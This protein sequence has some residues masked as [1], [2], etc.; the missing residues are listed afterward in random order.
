MLLYSLSLQYMDT[1]KITFRLEHSLNIVFH[2]KY[3]CKNVFFSLFCWTSC[4]LETFRRQYFSRLLFGLHF[5]FTLCIVPLFLL[6]SFFSAL[7]HLTL[8][9]VVVVYFFTQM[10]A[11]KTG[12]LK[13][14]HFFNSVPR[15]LQD[16]SDNTVQSR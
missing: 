9:V 6:G 10:F 12:L 8:F 15:G 4:L 2:C 11:L 5:P 3:I 1:K 16:Q 7:Y 13:T 14:R